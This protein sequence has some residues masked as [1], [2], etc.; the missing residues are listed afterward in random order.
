MQTLTLPLLQAALDKL[1]ASHY[2]Y[3]HGS[4]VNVTATATQSDHAAAYAVQFKL[5]ETGNR[6]YAQSFGG[7]VS[8]IASLS[9]YLAQFGYVTT[10]IAS[11]HAAASAGLDA[12]A[13]PLGQTI[14]LLPSANLP[15][16]EFIS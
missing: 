4:G 12:I 7:G 10:Y 13:Y 6:E 5:P 9:H 2:H 14:L 11:D 16:F 1:A 3:I 8:L 15:P